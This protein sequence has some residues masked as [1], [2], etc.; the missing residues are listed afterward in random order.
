MGAVRPRS[1]EHRSARL[2]DARRVKG[3][4][5]APHEEVAAR[6]A[7]PSGEARSKVVGPLDAAGATDHAGPEEQRFG[8]AKY[9]LVITRDLYARDAARDV[10]G[11]GAEGLEPDGGVRERGHRRQRKR[12]PHERAVHRPSRELAETIELIREVAGL[13]SARRDLAATV[14]HRPAYGGLASARLDRELPVRAFAPCD[15]AGVDARRP[16]DECVGGDERVGRA[17]EPYDDALGGGRHRKHLEGRLEDHTERSEGSDEELVEVV[18][19]D[20]LDDASSRADDRAVGEGDLR[21][22]EEIAHAAVARSPE[23]VRVRRDDSSD[24]G[25]ARVRRIERDELARAAQR[26][27]QIRPRPAGR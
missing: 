5:D 9:V 27:P 25:L 13:P 21:P 23:S 1:R 22:D 19:R 14:V 17:A 4:L 18:S 24:R 6:P 12:D 20:V 16:A 15:D 8:V 7:G 10:A 11:E 3:V 2:E 26:R